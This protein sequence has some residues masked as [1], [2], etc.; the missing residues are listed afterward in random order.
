M[1]PV[2]KTIDHVIMTKLYSGKSKNMEIVKMSTV[3]EERIN[4]QSTCL[5]QWNYSI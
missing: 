5:G 4:V 3:A 2:E 1:T